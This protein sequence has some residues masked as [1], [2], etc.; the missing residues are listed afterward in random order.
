[1]N[2]SANRTSRIEARI[3]LDFS[4]H[5]LRAGIRH[6]WVGW[7]LHSLS[8]CHVNSFFS[9]PVQASSRVASKVN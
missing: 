5:L 8:F 2:Q 6:A 4:T 1:M 7:P 9:L 3:F